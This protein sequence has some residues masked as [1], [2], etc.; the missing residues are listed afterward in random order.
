VSIPVV[1]EVAIGTNL[2]QCGIRGGRAAQARDY[3]SQISRDGIGG[4]MSGFT[5]LV[6]DDFL[7]APDEVR[8]LALR[9]TFVKMH[10]AGTRTIERFLHLAP[11]RDRFEKMSGRRLINWDENLANGR[12][13]CCLASDAVPYHSDTQSA[14]GV[15]FL[16]PNAPCEAGLSFFRSRVSG[17]RGRS[18]DP[19]LME[20]TFGGGAEFD[21]DCWEEV[22]RIGN[23]FNR[24]VLF[25][26][27]LAHG[28]SAYFGDTLANG[29][30][31]QNFFF[32][33]G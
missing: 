2:R 7:N 3:V 5:T 9:Q 27:Q 13:Q 14:A 6:V 21:R 25:D 22:D 1:L 26:A 24:L 16:T 4:L 10:S 30:L 12:F 23:L 20:L 28:A 8:A 15:L 19:H 17:L 29:R 33:F 18:S 11:Y 32:D 31:F